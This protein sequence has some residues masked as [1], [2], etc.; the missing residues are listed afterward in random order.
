MNVV[1]SVVVES[2]VVESAIVEDLI[3]PTVGLFENKS[4]I[5]TV[6][7]EPVESKNVHVFS[8]P[9]PVPKTVQVEESAPTPIRQQTEKFSTPLEKPISKKFS[10]PYS[11]STPRVRSSLRNQV[12]IPEKYPKD[13]KVGIAWTP[14][15]MAEGFIDDELED[16]EN[17][18]FVEENEITWIE[19]LWMGVKFF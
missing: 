14:L 2:T 15:K 6:Q 9:L 12:V 1:E 4:E 5:E 11:S 17:D 10:T 7:V 13:L 18:L 19:K 3:A 16:L 8:V